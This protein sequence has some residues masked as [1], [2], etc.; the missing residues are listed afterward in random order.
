MNLNRTLLTTTLLTTL[1]TPPVFAARGT[2]ASGA[3]DL[4][5]CVSCV[6]VPVNEQ[7][8]A[9]LT[10]M[11]EEEKLARDIYQ[12]AYESWLAPLFA[13]IAAAEQQ[14]MDAVGKMLSQYGLPDP[15]A[16]DIPGQFTDANLQSLYV[17]LAAQSELSLLDALQAGALIEEIDIEDNQNA[18]DGTDKLDLKTLYSNLLRGSRNHLRA[19][20]REI[21]RLGEVYT[22]QHLDQATVDLIVDSPTE[23]GGE[24]SQ[25]YGQR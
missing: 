15:V 18:L 12:L 14:H 5:T 13:N 21:E 11:R 2:G 19:L 25:K 24:G 23:R 20:V 7:E 10:F 17:Q 8:A 3:G 22:A 4:G 6:T 1:V 9:M 16:N